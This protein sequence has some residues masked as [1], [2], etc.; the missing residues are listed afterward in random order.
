MDGFGFEFFG[1]SV[2]I[3]QNYFLRTALVLRK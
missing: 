1:F 3:V 2:S